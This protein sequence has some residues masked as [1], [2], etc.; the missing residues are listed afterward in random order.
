MK[1]LYFM[2][3]HRPGFGYGHQ[4]G[5]GYFEQKFD[6]TDGMDRTHVR[7]Y[8]TCECCETR[9]QVGRIHLLS[10]QELLNSKNNLIKQRQRRN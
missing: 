2:F 1:L 7:L 5:Q 9:Y 4:E 8:S 6:T 3:G 10:K